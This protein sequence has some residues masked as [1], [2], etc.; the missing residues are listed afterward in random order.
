MWESTV[1]EQKSGNARVRNCDEN[2]FGRIRTERDATLPIPKLILS[3]LQVN[4]A[5]SLPRKREGR[6]HLK[7]PL[8]AFSGVRWE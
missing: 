2:G 7:I 8:N 5:G 6:R 3:T 1:A 4:I